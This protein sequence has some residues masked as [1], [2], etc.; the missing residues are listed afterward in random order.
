MVRCSRL[1]KDIDWQR[2]AALATALEIGV[3]YDACTRCIE[4]IVSCLL[5]K[6][7]ETFPSSWVVPSPAPLLRSSKAARKNMMQ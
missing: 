5:C 7:P 6:N 3:C 1:A 4:C 2:V